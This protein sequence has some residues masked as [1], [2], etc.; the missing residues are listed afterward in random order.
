MLMSLGRH[1]TITVATIFLVAVSAVLW[2]LGDGPPEQALKAAGAKLC[3]ANDETLLVGAFLEGD[4]FN[5]DHVVIAAK[6]PSLQRLSLAESK[7]TRSGIHALRALE[8]L[9]SLD[10]SRT[11]CT[12]DILDVV[13]SLTSLKE[14]RLDECDWLTDQDLG[15][16]KSLRRLESLSL[17]QTKVTA[18]ATE[19]LQQIPRLRVLGLDRCPEINDSSIE[20]LIRLCEHRSVNLSLSGTEIT[21]QGLLQ[22]RKALPSHAIHLRPDTMVGLREIGGR[23]HFTTNEL[24]EVWGFRRRADIDGMVYPLLAGDLKLLSNIPGIV[25]INL[26]DTNVDD[27]MLLELGQLPRLETLR[28]SSTRITD[29][30]L[31]VLAGMPNL[32]TLT[33]MDNNIDG[34]GLSN[35]QYVPQLTNLRI[36]TQSGDDVLSHL[37]GLTDLQMLSI[38][39]PITDAGTE[40][41]SDLP[42]LRYLALIATK[43]RA[44]GIEKLGVSSTLAELRFDGGMIDD[45][46]IESLA[47]LKSLKWMVF[48]QTK[49]TNAGRDRLLALRPDIAIHRSGDLAMGMIGLGR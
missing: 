31:K 42:K 44:A 1:V 8:R 3:F 35:L 25:D 2:P 18:A 32:K 33:L 13:A 48:Y 16:L 14:L 19:H 28:L 29:A 45:S 24:G 12:P 36:Q 9:S 26:E 49:V 40:Q 22:L 4:R 37:R 30:G 6:V 38:C 23:G 20:S 41:L 47:G 10:L 43:V 27:T 39:A 15:R 17:A 11:Q 7:V 46:D 21:S 34:A 5:D